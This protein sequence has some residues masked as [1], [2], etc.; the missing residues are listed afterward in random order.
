MSSTSPVPTRL[1]LPQALAGGTVVIIGGSSG[2]GLAAGQLLHAIGARVVLVGRNPDRLAAA[3]EKVRAA[4][5]TLAFSNAGES[6][7][8]AAQLSNERTI[9]VPAYEPADN[10][11]ARGRGVGAG[12]DQG[13]VGVAALERVIGVAADGGDEGRLGSIFDQVGSVDHVL[14][15]AG[16]YGGGPLGETPRSAVEDAVNARLWGAYA[17]A[18]VAAEHLPPG[19]SL[20]LSSGA[21]LT[22]PVPGAAA[23]IASIGAVEGLTRALAV[24]FAPRRLRVNTVR[25]GIFDT[26]LSRGAIGQGAGA[27]GDEAVR[28]AGATLPLG[29]FG[30][31]EE[32]AS[33]A[34][35]LMA[36]NYVTGT[37]L[38][39]D[40][41][42]ALG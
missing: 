21:Y 13:G 3:T 32:A 1:P 41:G 18:R 33:A 16:S 38:T 23:G 10:T 17:A 35:F 29:R 4:T 36:N 26:P 12:A 7:S 11:A 9:G 25:Y 8:T 24:E 34:L 5:E 19:G 37:A 27:E 20:T 2:I 22:R 40:G 31:P 39:I 28:K 14:V 42:H 30:T 15:T 6:S